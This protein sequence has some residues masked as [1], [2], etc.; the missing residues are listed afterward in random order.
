M[1]HSIISCRIITPTFLHGISKNVVEFREASFKG[2]L[3]Y[4]WRAITGWTET[5]EMYKRECELFGDS[6]DIKGKSPV[7]IKIEAVEEIQGHYY[8][9][10][11]KDN[12]RMKAFM[13]GSKYIIHLFSKENIE[14]YNSI[15]QAAIIMGGVGKRSRRG[16]G[17]SVIESIDG[18]AVGMD[19][20]EIGI[21]YLLNRIC[22]KETYRIK[23]GHRTIERISSSDF[24]YPVIKSIEIGKSYSSYNSLLKN[25]SIA[26]HEHNYDSLGYARNK[27][28]FASPIYISAYQHDKKILPVATT[29]TISLSNK[30]F[31]EEDMKKQSSFKEVIL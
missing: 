19:P 2:A 7:R 15:M 20:L 12:A 27:E 26:G 31:S 9:L 24:L 30:H 4:W 11:H 14:L 21:K 10:P 18:Q 16:F 1:H 3:R 8:L 5:S 22:D 25:I 13:P 23:S 28:R 17:S 29:L 6:N